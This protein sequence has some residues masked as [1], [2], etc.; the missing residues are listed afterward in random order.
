MQPEQ[1]TVCRK[2]ARLTAG[3][4]PRPGLPAVRAHRRVL[5]E[6][7]ALWVRQVHVGGGGLPRLRHFE[8]VSFEGSSDALGVPEQN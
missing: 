2:L 4:R 3:D 5:Q 8:W 1:H 7:V 6:V